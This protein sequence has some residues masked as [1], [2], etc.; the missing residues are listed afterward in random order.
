MLFRSKGVYHSYK[1]GTQKEFDVPGPVRDIVSSFYWFRLQEALPGKSVHT[2]VNSEE[3]NWDLNIQV[4]G[5]QTKVIRGLDSVDTFYVEPKTSLKGVFFSRGR[6]WVYFTADSR[7]VPVWVQFKT[8]FGPVNGVL[9]VR[10][11]Q[12]TK[13]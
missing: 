7:R 11:G 10:H 9:D 13:L 6:V 3:K 12:S 8:P 1:N 5:L 4:L 2:T